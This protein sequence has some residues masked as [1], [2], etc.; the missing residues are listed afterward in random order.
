MTI[1]HLGWNAHFAE[2]FEPYEAQGFAA[3]RVVRAGGGF[4]TLLD[5]E[6]ERTAT[7]AGQLRHAST[8]DALPVVGDWVIVDPAAAGVR[9]AAVLPRRTALRRA[10]AGGR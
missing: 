4:Y 8:P 5:G 6:T 2:H 10:A 7:L 3:A 1:E 9:I